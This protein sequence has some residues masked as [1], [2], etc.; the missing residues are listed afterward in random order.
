MGGVGGVGGT[1]GAA[2]VGGVGGVGGTSGAGSG[3]ASLLK[4]HFNRWWRRTF[5]P[6]FRV[7]AFE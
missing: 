6:P 7:F 4:E 3:P 5:L 2:G 1:G